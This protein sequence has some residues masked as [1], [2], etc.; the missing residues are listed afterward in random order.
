MRSFSTNYKY[1]PMYVICVKSIIL[2][3]SEQISKMDAISSISPNKL[4]ISQKFLLPDEARTKP[5]FEP[6]LD[7]QVFVFLQVLL[8]LFWYFVFIT[9]HNLVKADTFQ[10]FLLICRASP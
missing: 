1:F 8:L 2:F 3:S 7:S 6:S 10:V 4:K 9:W 5:R